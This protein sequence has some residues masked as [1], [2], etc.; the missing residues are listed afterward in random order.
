M[1]GTVEAAACASTVGGGAV[2]TL[3]KIFRNDVLYC[4]DLENKVHN[5]FTWGGF[6]FHFLK[7]VHDVFF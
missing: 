7:V 5:T 2:K 6:G 3:Q 1:G 4:I